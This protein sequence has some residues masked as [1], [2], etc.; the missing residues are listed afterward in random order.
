MQA[1]FCLC[2]ITKLECRSHV[3][4]EIIAAA[5]GAVITVAT[6]GIG[7]ASKRAIEGRDAV[8]RLTSAVEHVA[9]RL[10]SLHVDIKADRREMF[11]R[12]NSIEQR[13]ARLEGFHPS[14]NS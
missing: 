11:G 14:D 12:M 13:V 4:F 5:V 8:I 9:T 10:E 1:G 7:A 6:M 2:L 3:V